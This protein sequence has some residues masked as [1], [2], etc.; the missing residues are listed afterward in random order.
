MSPELF[1]LV[2]YVVMCAVI[3]PVVYTL[4]KRRW[5]RLA[6]LAVVPVTLLIAGWCFLMLLLMVH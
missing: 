5:S 4:I 1:G 6:G 3:G 2:V